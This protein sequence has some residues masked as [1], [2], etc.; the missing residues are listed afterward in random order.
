MAGGVGGPYPGDMRNLLLV[1]ALI[2]LGSA[3]EGS[4][5]ADTSDTGLTSRGVQV[6]SEGLLPG[7]TTEDVAG[8][9]LVDGFSSTPDQLADQLLGTLTATLAADGGAAA[10][11]LTLSRAGTLATTGDCP[12]TVVFELTGALDLRERLEG[13]PWEGGAAIEPSGTGRLLIGGSRFD[14]EIAP[15]FDPAGLEVVLRFDGTLDADGARGDLE[16]EGCAGPDCQL[17][18][19]GQLTAVRL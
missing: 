14:G 10:G 17:D 11:S 3:C 7:C 1:T 12:P 5:P 6:G 16:F 18:P 8:D 19:V 4:A 13:T 9:A 2:A 15:T